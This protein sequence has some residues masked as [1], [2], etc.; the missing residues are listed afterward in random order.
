M[1]SL[2]A[3]RSSAL[4]SVV[5]PSY[6]ASRYI[7]ETLESVLAQTYRNFEVIVIDDGS[8]DQTP[9][10]VADYARRDSRIRLVNQPNSGVGVA[11]N[12]GIAEAS[13]KFIAPSMPTI[14]GIRKNSRS[15]SRASRGAGKNG[16]LPIVGRNRSTNVARSSCHLLTGRFAEK[17]SMH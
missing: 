1:S 2:S 11:R 7:C 5:V 15:R 3:K 17:F 10:I 13:G 4:V 14:S 8:K 16:D 6:N 9:D 12:R